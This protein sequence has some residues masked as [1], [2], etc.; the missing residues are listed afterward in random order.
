MRIKLDENVPTSVLTLLGD[1]GFSVDTV[2]DEGL[3]GAPDPE[4]LVAATRE[5]RTVITLDRGFGDIRRYPPGAHSGIVVLRLRSDGAG[6]VRA[7]IE[8]LL[9]SHDIADLHGTV[10]VVHDDTLRIRRP[11]K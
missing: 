5:D 1:R 9:D 4:V 11:N 8:S 6:A 7:A 2:A 3:A 10:T